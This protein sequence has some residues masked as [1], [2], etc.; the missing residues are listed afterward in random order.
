[1]IYSPTCSYSL[2]ITVKTILRHSSPLHPHHLFVFAKFASDLRSHK[3]D[4]N[5]SP[6][7][8]VGLELTKRKKEE[9]SFQKWRG[10]ICLLSEVSTLG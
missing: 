8:L 6:Q 7:F 5:Q 3:Q 4:E 10:F 2:I 1:M 9:G